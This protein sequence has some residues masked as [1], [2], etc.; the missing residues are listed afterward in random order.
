MPFS[1]DQWPLQISSRQNEGAN[2]YSKRW[3]VLIKSCE[4]ERGSNPRRS[5]RHRPDGNTLSNR[6]MTALNN[7]KK[8]LTVFLNWGGIPSGRRATALMPFC[9]CVNP[10]SPGDGVTE[11]LVLVSS[12]ATKPFLH[13]YFVT[14]SLS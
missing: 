12:P 14:K 9:H 13:F 11:N 10:E 6:A 1:M 2:W 7:N 3:K 5:V 4:S 8:V